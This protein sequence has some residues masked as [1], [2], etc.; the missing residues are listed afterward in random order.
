MMWNSKVYDYLKSRK[1]IHLAA[2]L[3][4]PQ[5]V[6]GVLTVEQWLAPEIPPLD[7]FQLTADATDALLMAELRSTRALEVKARTKRFIHLRNEVQPLLYGI[8]WNQMSVDSQD[9][10]S[11]D[12]DFN[13]A[14]LNS[15]S[16]RLY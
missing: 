15:D 5:L 12:P 6:N 9:K 11:S 16:Q 8:L 3:L 13:D 14:M 2:N 10:V 1:D 7:S 4:N